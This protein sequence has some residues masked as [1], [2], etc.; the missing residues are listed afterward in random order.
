MDTEPKKIIYEFGPHSPASRD[1][2]LYTKE[3]SN[4][5]QDKKDVRTPT[6]KQKKTRVFI[7]NIK[8]VL[9]PEDYSPINQ[10]ATMFARDAGERSKKF[11]CGQIFDSSDAGRAY[12]EQDENH[13]KILKGIIKQ[14]IHI[15]LQSY[16]TQ[17]QKNSIYEPDKFINYEGIAQ[18]LKKAQMNCFYCKTPV[19]LLYQHVREPK[20]WTLERINNNFGHNFGNVE[21]ACLSCNLRRRCINYERFL[22]TKQLVIVKNT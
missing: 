5:T 8:Q 6:I 9:Q 18:L 10:W 11:G 7:E 12:G 14:H 4:N 1:N 15:K 2:F 3:N 13:Q 21:I 22:F 16:K 17:D 19:Q 20:Q